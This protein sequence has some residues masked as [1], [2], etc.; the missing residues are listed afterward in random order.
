MREPKHDG[1]THIFWT[2]DGRE[3]SCSP[4]PNHSIE[5]VAARMVPAGVKWEA[6]PAETR[7][8]P[9]APEAPAVDIGGV[10]VEPAAA[11]ASLP[12][13][14]AKVNELVHALARKT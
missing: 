11:E 4:S 3:F 7:V 9:P 14:T 12:E 10:S 2:I 5:S 6:R 8:R 1:K 13:L